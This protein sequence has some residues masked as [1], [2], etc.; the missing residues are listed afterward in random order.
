MLELPAPFDEALVN[1][2]KVH[3]L[4]EVICLYGFT[5]LEPPPTSAESELDDIQLAVDGADLARSVEWLPAIE[6][7]GEGIFLHFSNDFIRRWLSQDGVAE[8]AGRLRGAR[9]G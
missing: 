2:V 8:K 9:G 7:F 6:Q 3:R 4:R 1:V 5:R